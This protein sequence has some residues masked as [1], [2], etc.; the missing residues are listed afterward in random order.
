MNH[1]LSSAIRGGAMIFSFGVLAFGARAE[2]FTGALARAYQNNPSLNQQRANLRAHDED[3]PK[4]AAGM[5]PVLGA[6]ANAGVQYSHFRQPLGTNSFG[7]TAF[8]TGEFL[9]SPKGGN[10]SASQTLFDGWRTAN[11]TRQAEASVMAGREA[12]RRVEQS[13]LLDAVKAYMLVLR[14]TAIVRLRNSNV[15]VLAEQLN[16][17][18]IRAELR[19]ISVTDVAQAEAALALARSDA[20]EAQATLKESAATYRQV[21]GVEPSRLEAAP[22]I[23]AAL[24]RSAAAAMRIAL[25]EHPDVLA[26]THQIAGAELSVKIAEG[27][28]APTVSAGVQV[29]QQ[30][31][32]FFGV[33]GSRQFAAQ[34]GVTLNVPLYQGGAEYASIRKAK[35]Q[36]GEARLAADDQR[37]VVRTAV[38]SSLARLDSAKT[39][40]ASSAAA[41]RSAEIALGGVRQEAAVGQRTT[42]DILNAQ[43]SLLN[44]RLR[45]VAS[46][47]TKVV[48]SYSV[49]AAIG[50]LSPGM[51][52]LGVDIYSP[53]RHF[54]QVRDKWFG[55]TP[56]T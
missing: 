31:D 6:A 54:N 18:R 45:L 52:K 4:A 38:M 1:A 44:A 36:L 10:F 50:R 5:R 22:N 12:L 28:L 34:G 43:Q 14:D 49:L 30:Y 32:S 3:V 29:Y 46:Q 2:T 40:I 15:Q 48:A 8:T 19:E 25:L 37:N 23:D 35:E 47:Y 53:E 9:G 24:P 39:S 33:T 26:S 7:N 27:A 20:A 11:S 51:L 42:F 17:T 13:T 56:P 21:I 41:V 16:Q 55:L